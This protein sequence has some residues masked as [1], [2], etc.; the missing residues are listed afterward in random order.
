M[1]IFNVFQI[2]RKTQYQI[3]P[4]LSLPAH[5]IYEIYVPPAPVPLSS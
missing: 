3:C 2:D 4:S 5:F 1:V